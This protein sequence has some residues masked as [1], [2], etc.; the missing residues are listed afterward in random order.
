MVSLGGYGF[1]RRADAGTFP[2]GRASATGARVGK[3]GGR[4]S[5]ARDFNARVSVR[6]CK[7]R[8][9]P[10]INKP[11]YIDE[12]GCHRPIDPPPAVVRK[13]RPCLSELDKLVRLQWRNAIENLHVP[14]ARIF[15]FLVDEFYDGKPSSKLLRLLGVKP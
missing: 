3:P 9:T 2:G 11:G 10:Q 14:T 4:A 12:C 8:F 13:E 5:E 15:W 6:P 7:E 1:D